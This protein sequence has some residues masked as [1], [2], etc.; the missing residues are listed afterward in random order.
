MELNGQLA[1][2]ILYLNVRG[3]ELRKT[4]RFRYPQ[5]PPAGDRYTN[6]VASR[7][8][9]SSAFVPNPPTHAH[10]QDLFFQPPA[11]AGFGQ[12]VTANFNGDGKPDLT[13]ADGSVL[14]GKRDS[15]LTLGTPLGVGG[16][17]HSNGNGKPE[18]LH[19]AFTNP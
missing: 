4:N 7:L 11:Y 12:S 17:N 9:S 3:R 18:L 16:Q 10:G 15:T 13:S 1:Y 19:R 6:L 2:L 8:R 14:L 5:M